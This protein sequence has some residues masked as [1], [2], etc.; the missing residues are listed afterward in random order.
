MEKTKFN[1]WTQLLCCKELNA[2]QLRVLMLILNYHNLDAWDNTSLSRLAKD[3]NASVN[4]ISS[5]RDVLEKM[6][7]ITKVVSNY[8]KNY[9]ATLD[10]L[11]NYE[12]IQ[13]MIDGYSNICASGISKID[14][15]G[16]SKID[17]KDNINKITSVS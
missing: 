12:R 2:I 7:L 17:N 10:Y 5:A 1:Q 11:P 8:K 6:G 16:I 15:R 13:K 9:K 3:C 14:N 4:C